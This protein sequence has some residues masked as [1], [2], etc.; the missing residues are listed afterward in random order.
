MSIHPEYWLSLDL[1]SPVGSLS[2]HERLGQ[3]NPRLLL[4]KIITTSGDHS[5]RFVPA[6]QEGLIT[7]G[8]SP[9]S[10]SKFVTSSGPGSFTGLRIAFASLKALAY[11]NLTPIEV[12]SGSE[13]RALHWVR[14]QKLKNY[15]KIHV[16]TYITV[17]RFVSADFEIG[18]DGRLNLV[19]ESSFNDW[20][21]LEA[22]PTVAVL[23]DSRAHQIHSSQFKNNS[24][25]CT[26]LTAE[27]LGE[28]LLSAQTRKTC[29]TIQEWIELSPNY[30]GSTRY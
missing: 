1:S 12:L 29:T 20:S 23:L 25:F 9:K 4:S 5:E 8:I 17:E 28:A 16:I 14:T 2:I 3:E 27:L 26:D 10:F 15:K 19:S 21:F 7:T 30:F 11:N 22:H 18:S 13:A 6:L 24:I